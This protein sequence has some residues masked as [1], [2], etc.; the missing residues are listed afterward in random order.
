[1]TCLDQKICP[2]QNMSS[3][4]QTKHNY[5]NQPCPQ[6]Y[7]QWNNGFSSGCKPIAEDRRHLAL[8]FGKSRETPSPRV[9]QADGLNLNQMAVENALYH[10]AASGDIKAV[11]DT[12]QAGATHFDQAYAIAQHYGHQQVMDYLRMWGARG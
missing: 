4:R 6:G 10:A 11:S 1:M 7:Y 2:N 12:I 9:D 5:P 8:Q 3:P